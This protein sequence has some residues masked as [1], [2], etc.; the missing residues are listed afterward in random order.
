[1]EK[2]FE[3]DA[4]MHSL[5]KNGGLERPSPDFTKN[6]ITLI[7]AQASATSHTVYKPLLSQKALFCIAFAFVCIP[8]AAY[9][10]PTEPN[11]YIASINIVW[12]TI[13]S[14]SIPEVSTSQ[15]MLYAIAFLGLFLMEIPFLKSQ[16]LKK[17]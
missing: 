12:N 9:F 11:K 3:D 6:V 13:S 2:R 8:L 5:M 4:F 1:M 15:T 14:L 10:L 7:E 16:L 17:D